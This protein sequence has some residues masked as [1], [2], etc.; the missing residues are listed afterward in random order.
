MTDQL[1][2]PGSQHVDAII[3]AYIEAV[4]AG[5]APDRQ[6]LL[7]HH[8]DLAAELA[9]FFADH[10]KVQQLA[11]PLRADAEPPTL[12]PRETVPSPGIVLRHFG[13][14]ELLAEIARGGMGVVYKA[15]QISLN[16][17]V[18]LKMILAGQLA[19]EADVQRFQ[20]E[21]RTAA[22]LQHPNIVAI[23]EVGRHDGQDFFSMDFVEG[24]SLADL[25]REHPLPPAQA[26]RYVKIIAE[27]IAYAHQ[28]GTLHRDLKPSNVLI[29]AFDQPRVTDF[30]LARPI[31]AEKGLTA[32]GAVV[33]TPSYMP[34][35]QASADRGKLGPAS[36]VY[37]L[38][39]V[40]YELV[41]GRPP[42][43]A[44]T[45]FDTLMQVLQDEPAAPRLLNPQIGRDLETVILKC[46][47]KDAAKRYL[48]AQALADDLQAFLE[49][50]PVQAR[51]PSAV[52]RAVRWVRKQRRGVI[53][54]TA[55]AAASVVLVVGAVLGWSWWSSWRLAHVS[56][57]AADPYYLK[58]DVLDEQGETVVARFTV[59]TNE[60][61]ALAPGSYQVRLAREGQLSATYRLFAEPHRQYHFRSPLPERQL[62]EVPAS[63]VVQVVQLDGKP[64]L[65]QITE[66]G[67]RRLDGATG[68][69]V[70][71]GDLVS[72]DAKDQPAAGQRKDYP[73]TEV[74][75]PGFV[76]FKA[77][78]LPGLVPFVPDRGG[79]G[80]CN[81]VVASRRLPCLLAFSG[82][83]GKLLWWYRARLP[84][85]AGMK[86]EDVDY[87][88]NSSGN[89]KVIGQPLMADVNRDGT[90]DFITTFALPAETIF[91]KQRGF[92]HQQ[93]A[94][95]V[96]AVSGKNGQS[97]W[98]YDL[99]EQAAYVGAA[100]I[101]YAAVVTRLNQEPIVA[102]VV[103]SRL[104]GLHLHTGKEVWPAL[105]VGSELL[106]APQFLAL[107][108][109]G[110]PDAVLLEKKAQ[111]GVVVEVISLWDRK[112][113][114]QAVE[115]ADG[116]NGNSRP[117]QDPLVTILQKAGRPEVVALYRQ[118]NPGSNEAR[119]TVRDA[120]TGEIRWSRRWPRMQWSGLIVMDP[121][122]SECVMVGPDLDG[123]GFHE[124]FVATIQEGRIR[125]EFQE[126]DLFVDC[127]SGADGH[128]LWSSPVDSF[129]SAS[130]MD[131]FHWWQTGSDGWP[132][133]VVSCRRH[134]HAIADPGKW[135][136]YALSATTG[137]VEYTVPAFRALG[138]ADFNRDGLPDLYGAV[139]G[140]AKV[141][142]LRGSAV[143]P[144]RILGTGWQPAQDFDGDGIADLINVNDGHVT[145]LSGRD[146][147]RLWQ[148][149]AGVVANTMTL[150]P[151]GDLDGDGVPDLLFAE[152]DSGIAGGTYSVLVRALSGGTGK[153]LWS[154]NLSAHVGQHISITNQRIPYLRSHRFTAEGSPD[155]LA[156]YVVG[157]F[158][159]AQQCW[160]ARISGRNGK[161][162]WNQPLHDKSLQGVETLSF[163]P[164]LVDLDED[165]VLDLV[166]W[167]PDSD[168]AGSNLGV[169]C[170]LCAFSG[171]DGTLLWVGPRLNSYQMGGPN[172]GFG[173]P[174]PV[175]LH[176]ADGGIPDIVVSLCGREPGQAQQPFGEVLI[177]GGRDGQVKWRWRGDDGDQLNHGSE[178]HDSAPQLVRLGTGPALL[179]SIHDRALTTR[180]D[181]KS[182]LLQP[183]GKSGRQLV[184]LDPAR[185]EVRQ[186]RDF[187]EAVPNR[188]R[189]WTQDLDG[190][191][192]DE[193]V[194]LSDG[195]VHATHGGILD[196]MWTWTPPSSDTSIMQIEPAKAGR[197]ATVVVR[198]G[199]SI[200]G[201]DGATGQPRWRCEVEGNTAP[202]LLHTDDPQGLPRVVFAKESTFIC[203]MALP[204]GPSGEYVVPA[205]TPISGSP[206][207]DDPRLL[208]PLPWTWTGRIAGRD[209]LEIF[210]AFAFMAVGLYVPGWLLYWA[211]RRRSWKPA[212]VALLWLGSVVLLTYLR[213]GS[214]GLLMLSFQSALVFA[215][216]VVPLF[217][218]GLLFRSALVR[219]WKT[220][221]WLLTSFLAATL[222][223]AGAWL[224]FDARRMDPSEHYTWRGWYVVL[225]IG[226]YAWPIVAVAAIGLRALFRFGWWLLSRLVR[227]PQPA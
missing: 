117:G 80:T 97:L 26:A 161:V 27:A 81:L 213:Y 64:D 178:W 176:G 175:A 8:P 9:A 11:E 192:H 47:A 217:S 19:S 98:R 17:V 195:K 61:V 198:S 171:R 155:V 37:S 190:D 67:L 168:Q 101:P 172:T 102:L 156:S 124:L 72:L 130:G 2:D 223:I 169:A 42:F 119:L 113:L 147:H 32:T 68:K 24:R 76:P 34:P 204:V 112:Q 159:A 96:E 109:H 123:D 51:R 200:Y 150:Q 158:S 31:A 185:R 165:G 177:L 166:L 53:L 56:M 66:K 83:T 48:T 151:D 25:V 203:R 221:A 186:R 41:T 69:S 20:S 15:R 191:G 201:L 212:L 214:S 59:P 52:E 182:G 132:L 170:R 162:L 160:M 110:D 94:Q 144:W 219:R 122:L 43:R 136:T 140:G 211:R 91:S 100:Q 39:A 128:T 87:R 125:R 13:D 63:A 209:L 82:K 224:A 167:V 134:E 197:P 131:A 141:R 6:E 206:R 226:A 148:V 71:P 153:R 218:L 138:V 29:D 93:P 146:G 5:R 194:F 180:P 225:L 74:I 46:L 164:A 139:E 18:A 38:G 12:P 173:L 90:P 183:T 10:D 152:Q 222:L 95:C 79:D 220:V 4:E 23:H 84:P 3:A 92:V 193:V 115:K 88:S 143:E 44:A 78:Q 174:R 187:P 106:R 99:D 215:G 107:S 14:Y 163:E 21:A 1:N 62:W 104:V 154:C 35:E 54:T 120:A 121:L 30:G 216:S 55:T 73:G 114:W 208:R 196:E 157:E 135:Q 103:G 116:W 118:Q 179:V 137:Q 57:E 133:L 126:G 86:E 50:R 33:G 60:P 108:G 227:R 16:R 149:D 145:A 129:P 70:W 210:Q 7:A 36:D 75:Q 127:L 111:G 142:A 188:A 40:L 202:F 199:A 45:T 205:P 181:P 207:L 22:N 77:P 65:I 85:P 58:A 184:L 49:G 28:Q 189:F 89:D 105:N